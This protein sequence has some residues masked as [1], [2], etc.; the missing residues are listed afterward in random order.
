MESV[1]YHIVK[2]DEIK[3]TE[4]HRTFNELVD[5]FDMYQKMLGEDVSGIIETQKQEA[6]KALKGINRGIRDVI[7]RDLR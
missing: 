4:L 6:I 3:D 5:T 7:K 2:A 1:K